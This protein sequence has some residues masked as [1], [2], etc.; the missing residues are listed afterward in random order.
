M[1]LQFALHT[2]LKMCPVL[3]V[4]KVTCNV[5]CNVVYKLTCIVVVYKV[6][7]SLNGGARSAPRNVTSV[8]SEGTCLYEPLLDGQTYDIWIRA[9]DIMGN[10]RVS[11][12]HPG[13]TSHGVLQ[14]KSLTS[15]PQGWHH[16]EWKSKC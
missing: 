10:N 4:Y 5:V 13:H 14:G 2:L 11:V 8:K 1:I 12:L 16:G 9:T 15:G 6:T 7:W 3:L